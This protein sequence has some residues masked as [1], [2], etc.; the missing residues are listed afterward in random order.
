MP[1]RAD[2]VLLDLRRPRQQVPVVVGT[3]EVTP[4]AVNVIEVDATISPSVG[5]AALEEEK[6]KDKKK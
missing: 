6:D 1:S 4:G 3:T 5:R 2:P